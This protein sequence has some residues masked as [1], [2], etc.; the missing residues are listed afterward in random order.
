MPPSTLT[1]AIKFRG[2]AVTPDGRTVLC[3]FNDI[4]GEE[5]VFGL[6][7]DD[8]AIIGTKII[9]GYTEALKRSGQKGVVTQWVEEGQFRRAAQSS[10]AELTLTVGGG[11]RLA[12]RLS[13]AA[14]KRLNERLEEFL[15]T[16]EP[17]PRP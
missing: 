3:K 14:A 6:D 1:T 7:R 13:Y 8:S 5:I 12:F 17:L 16:D 10:D 4:N 9:A 2:T 15:A 11:G